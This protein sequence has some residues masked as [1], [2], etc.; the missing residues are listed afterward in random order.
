[1]GKTYKNLSQHVSHELDVRHFTHKILA[2]KQKMLCL[3]DGLK[4]QNGLVST[5]KTK[6]S[7][8]V[9]LFLGPF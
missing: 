4:L 1:M 6:T 3:M 9:G 2:V 8:A 5:I 7:E